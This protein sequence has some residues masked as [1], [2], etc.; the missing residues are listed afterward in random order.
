MFVQINSG[1]IR[2]VRGFLVN[3]EADAGTGLPGFSMVGHLA[4]EVREAQDRVRTA[5]KNTGFRLP[6]RK[7]TVSLSPGNVRK[8]GT[9]YDLPIAAAVLGAYGMVDFSEMRD[10]MILGELGLDGRVKPVRGVLSL[11]A[12]AR[13]QGLKRCFVPEENA[14]EAALVEKIQVIPVKSLAHMVSMA[15]DPVSIR[16][17]DRPERK[18]ELL[19]KQ[20]DEALDFCQ[21]KGQACLRRGAEIAAAG[22][23]NLLLGGPAGTGKTMVAR[24][25]PS[26]LPPLDWEEA[27]EISKVYSICGQLPENQPLITKRPFRSPHHTV[28]V[29]ALTGGGRPV[30]P[31]EFSLASGG[32]LFLCET[33]CTAN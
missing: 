15:Q 20:P 13:E 11:T 33:L 7:I 29:Q 14:A 25:I 26:I 28:T 6:A 2:A 4:P 3:V 9:Q 22:M 30:R 12:A 5:M 31:G 18:G 8:E 1:G 19:L 24:R 10:S 21:V 17:Y 23:H 27:M 32:V 16:P